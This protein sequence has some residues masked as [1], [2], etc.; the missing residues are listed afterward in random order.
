M[1]EVYFGNAL[2]Q[3][4]YAE[5][6]EKT[7]TAVNNVCETLAKTP[8]PFKEYDVIKIKGREACYRIRIGKFRILYHVDE[9][10]MKIYILSI[11]RRSETTYD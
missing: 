10:L 5:L 8:V 6:D 7:R 4:D 3:K 2:A 11:E 1:F 9:A